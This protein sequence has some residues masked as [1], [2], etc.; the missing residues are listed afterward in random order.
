M[1]RCSSASNC[2]CTC[3]TVYPPYTSSPSEFVRKAWDWKAAKSAFD[4]SDY[5]YGYC[6]GLDDFLSNFFDK[7]AVSQNE[8]LSML[9]V[10]DG[11]Y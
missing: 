2:S 7:E 4:E 8:I 5:W 3:P 6:T 1:G 9:N 11:N 10:L